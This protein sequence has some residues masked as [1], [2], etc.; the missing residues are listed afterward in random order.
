MTSAS[1]Y[2]AGVHQVKTSDHGC[3]AALGAARR[4]CRS[5]LI[6]LLALATS[7]ASA[8][9][10]AT[11]EVAGVAR[12]EVIPAGDQ[13]FDL[14]TGETVLPDGGTIR[15]RVTGLALQASIIRLQEGVYVEAENVTAERQGATF[16]APRLLVDL[17]RRV[18]TTPD[19]VTFRGAGLDVQAERADIDFDAEVVRFDA[20]VAERPSF[21]AQSFFLDLVEGDALLIGPYAYA[22]G[23]VAVRDEREDAM[24]QLTA[25]TQEDGTRT[26]RT[27]SVV[28]EALLAR[29]DAVR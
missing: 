21:E 3:S 19:G 4:V 5:L 6:L 17:Q 8:Q 16:E 14:L 18:A 13:T 12:L 26:Y 28:D 25:I 15:D 7:L 23:I 1:G 27:S 24:L 20:P 22:E 11:D 9:S 29:F 10:S 2:D